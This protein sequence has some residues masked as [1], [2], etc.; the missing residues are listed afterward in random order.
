MLILRAEPIPEAIQKASTMS[1]EELL[2]S[3]DW[4]YSKHFEDMTSEDHEFAKG[5]F[6]EDLDMY[7]SM[8]PESPR[9]DSEVEPGLPGRRDRGRRR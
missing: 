7:L 3:G 1:A 5:L 8:K 4:M 9:V 6:G 2:E